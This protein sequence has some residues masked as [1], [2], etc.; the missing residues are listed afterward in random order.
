MM[1]MLSSA[2]ALKNEIKDR[3]KRSRQRQAK[4][5]ALALRSERNQPCGRPQEPRGCGSRKVVE[6]LVVSLTSFPVRTGALHLVIRGLLAQSL[7]P[8]KT[9]I[10]LAREFPDRTV[11]NELSALA[12]DRSEIPSAQAKQGTE[13]N[14]PGGTRLRQ[15]SSSVIQPSS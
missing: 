5:F 10:P 6:D 14:E 4:R 13:R 8:R 9:S 15:T 12:G 1:A 7:Q 2:P 3:V 11:P